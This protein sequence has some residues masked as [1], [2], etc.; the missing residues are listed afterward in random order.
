M[1]VAEQKRKE[2][3]AEYILYMWQIEDTIRA[4]DFD[5][6]RITEYVHEGY[7][8][9]KPMMEKMCIRDR[10]EGRGST[11]SGSQDPPCPH[12]TYR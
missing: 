11:R 5:L 9:E 4:L 8:L 7:R 12:C 1:I 10:A 2:N 3:V 6:T